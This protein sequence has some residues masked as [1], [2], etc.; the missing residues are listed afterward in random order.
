MTTKSNTIKSLGLQAFLDERYYKYGG[1]L[2][3]IKMIEAGDND[4]KIGTAFN[5]KR[6][7]ARYWR[8]IFE[9]NK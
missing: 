6:Q 5:V 1:Y 4:T 2:Q 8:E 3:F 9:A 7:S